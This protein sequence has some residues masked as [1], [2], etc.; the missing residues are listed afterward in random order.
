MRVAIIG[1]G[2]AGLLTGAALARRGHQVTA[3]D[4]DPG[5][6]EDGSWPRRGVMQFHH[7]HGF[8]GQV[9]SALRAEMPLAYDA[10][11]S[12]GAEPIAMPLPGGNEEL[13]G[14][15]SRRST[16]EAAVRATAVQQDGFTLSRGHVDEVI[17]RDGRAAG[18]RVEGGTL[19]ADLVIDAS[20]RAGRATRALRP[21]PVIGGNCGIAYV[22]RQ[23]QLHSGAEFGP[24]TNP[25]AFQA[26]YDGYLVLVFPHEYGTFSIVIVRSTADRDLV[27]LRHETAFEAAVRAIPALAQWTDPERSRPITPVLPGGTLMNVYRSQTGPDGELALPGLIFL[28]DAVCTTTPNFGRGVA[29]TTM[30]CV[31]LLR[32]IDEH[33]NDLAEVGAQ[34]E[35]WC[36]TNM[37]PWV[38]DHIMMDDSLRDRWDGNDV[39]LSQPLPSDL[40]MEAAQVDPAIGPAIG[41]YAAMMAGPASLRVVE[42]LARAVY[43]TGW[44]PS[45]APGPTRD[46]LAE[47]TRSALQRA[48]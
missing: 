40:I 39:D 30:Q 7:A 34:F 15:R 22:D 26:T 12:A 5:P 13:I 42:P 6:A 41:P 38:A 9:A 46:E 43:E 20:G 32:L 45:L 19:E 8:R 35:G 3:V 4:R 47:I 10:W 17:A 1:A 14:M 2:P 31:E 23:Y 18:L 48:T 36:D 29:T 44:R 24:M 28:G 37:K 16:F 21:T 27:Q 33:G 11:I 25:I